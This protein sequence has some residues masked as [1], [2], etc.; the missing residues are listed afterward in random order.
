MVKT[1]PPTAPPPLDAGAAEETLPPHWPA[2][3]PHIQDFIDICSLAA[4]CRRHDGEQDF[5]KVLPQTDGAWN[6]TPD[7]GQ[8]SLSERWMEQLGLAP[9][10]LPL[11]PDAC[12][13][14]LHPDDAARTLQ[15]MEDCAQ[16]K[17]A[18]FSV[19]F[20]LRHKDGSYRWMLCR[21]G[22]LRDASGRVARVAGANTDITAQ[23]EA[24][25]ALRESE[26]RF[27]LLSQNTPDAVFLH[28]MAGNVLNVND[29][30]CLMLGYDKE[31]LTRLNVADFEVS[32]PAEVLHGIWANMQPGPFRFEGL[33]RRADGT[34]FPTEVH[35]VAF[36]ERGRTLSLL[37]ARDLTLRKQH[38][39]SLAEARDAAMAA[40]RAKTEFLANMSHEIRTPVHIILGMA[41][42]LR[43]TALAPKQAR[44]LVSLESAGQVL[45]HLIN[46]ILDI[47]QIEAQKLEL[48]PQR[49][50]PAALVGQVRDMMAVA[51]EEKG[52]SFSVRLDAGLP[53]VMVN[54]P[55]RVR[56]VLLNLLWNAVKFTTSGGITLE[57]ARV[58]APDASS[59]SPA[60]RLAV[61][62]TGVGIA[63][64]DCERIFAPFTQAR[65][66]GRPAGTGLGL[67][68]CKSLVERM[69]GAI[70]VDSVPGRGSRFTCTL[71]SLPGEGR[72]APRP[73][74][75]AAPPPPPP[76]RQRRLL[77]VE[78]SL[79]NREMVRLFLEKE[80][81]EIVVADTGVSALAQFAPGRFDIVLMDMEMP[82]MDGCAAT[83]AIRRLEAASGTW[84]TP[85][86]MLSAH[87]F[88]DYERKAL[89][90]G[91][92]AFLTKPVRKATLLDALHGM[93]AAP[94]HD[95]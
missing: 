7:T 91:C 22:A 73:E 71:P 87:A 68:I 72:D 70:S 67:A 84:R 62:D 58:D 9:D 12:S 46:D 4:D 39:A 66:G 32:C 47:S 78:D 17:I 27:R 44:Y 14:R 53:A 85:V 41:E 76:A 2:P 52:L 40:N 18:S 42:L 90:A 88:A 56:Q 21:G 60:L 43:E 81:Y 55:D 95:D 6:W 59:G 8:I 5:A 86:L 75:A 94:R 13:K 25:Q 64:E 30:A 10:E 37:A 50:D 69:G 82:E 63:P 16:G 26:A 36:L 35:G 29:H 48:R 24:E 1:P 61:T 77:L 33:A 79:A 93:F 23:K 3:S 19:E 15:L 20:R 11:A 80:P 51:V 65:A 74:S 31:A 38:E 45:L 34:T 89:A 83:E 57:A 92:D 28:D 49:F 54:D